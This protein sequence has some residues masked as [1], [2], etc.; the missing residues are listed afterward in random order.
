MLPT[1][2]WHDFWSGR[3]LEGGRT[4]EVNNTFAAIPVYVR[5]DAVVPWAAP[6]ASTS[7]DAARELRVRVYG[8]GRTPWQGAGPDLEGL[9]LSWD[10]D[11][12]R[13]TVTPARSAAR[14]YRITGWEKIG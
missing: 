11:A 3:E 1:G 7:D 12:Q 6:A 2:A 9:M 14:P 13:G 10:A 8:S 4:I 5:G